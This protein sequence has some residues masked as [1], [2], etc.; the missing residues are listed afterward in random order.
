[1]FYKRPNQNRPPIGNEILKYRTEN[2]K[3]LSLSRYLFDNPTE[4]FEA[5]HIYNPLSKNQF[6]PTVNESAVVI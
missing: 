6:D 2:A 4:Q 3:Y 1:M 5:L